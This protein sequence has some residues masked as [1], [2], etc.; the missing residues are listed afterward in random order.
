MRYCCARWVSLR[1][2]ELAVLTIRKLK[3]AG[4][5]MNLVWFFR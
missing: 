1:P 2:L 5:K 3:P 4:T